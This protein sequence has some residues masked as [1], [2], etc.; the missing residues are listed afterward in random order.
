MKMLR[1]AGI[2]QR[3]ISRGSCREKINSTNAANGPKIALL[4][5]MVFCNPKLLPVSPLV[6]EPAIRLSRAD[7]LADLSIKRR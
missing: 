3:K 4:L 6:T 5:S 2:P 7:A 1:I